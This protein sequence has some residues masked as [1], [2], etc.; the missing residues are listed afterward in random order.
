MVRVEA[1]LNVQLVSVNS[2][3]VALRLYLLMECG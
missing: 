1:A 3:L 2:T